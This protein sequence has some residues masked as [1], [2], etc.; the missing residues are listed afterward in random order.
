MQQN[1]FAR[2]SSVDD[3]FLSFIHEG[4]ASSEVLVANT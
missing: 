1:V 3:D 4:P 2:R